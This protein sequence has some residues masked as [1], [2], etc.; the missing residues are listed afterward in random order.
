MS[1]DSQFKNLLSPGRI[2]GMPLR[3]RIVMAPMGTNLGNAEGFTTEQMKRYYEERAKGGAGLITV[4]IAAV[5]YP[6]G[7]GMVNQLGISDDKFMPGLSELAEALQ[8]HGAKAAIQLHH[9]GKI[10]TN[11]MAAGLEPISPS[12]IPIPLDAVLK[13]LTMEE[14]MKIASRFTTIPEGGPK[15]RELSPDEI[16]GIVERYAEAADRAKR[17]SFDGVEIHS[18]H[19]YLIGQFL[20][21]ASNLR[22]DAYGGDLRN[23][24]RLLVEVIRAIRGSVGPHYPVWCRLDSREYRTENGITVEEAMEIAQMAAEAGID[25]LH[26]SAYGGASGIG[27]SE[28]PFVTEPGALLPFAGRI[29]RAVNIPVIA[30][31]R[32]SP[33]LGERALRSDQAD[34]ISIGRQLLADPELPNKLA[35]DRA[36]DIRP[37][38]CC[39]TC[40]SQIYINESVRCVV[41]PAVGKE[42][43]FDVRPAERPKRVLVVGGGPGG[44]QAAITSAQRGHQVTLC[45]KERRLGG[46][47]AFAAIP[48]EENQDLIDY[49][50][51]QIDRLSIDVKLEQD[52]SQGFINSVNPDAVIVAVGAKRTPPP[53][54]GVRKSR[55]LDG[56]DLRQIM[57]GQPEGE[58]AQKLSRLD[59][60]LLSLGRPVLD[61]TSWAREF[62]KH[63]LPILG[64]RI[65]IIG[66]DLVGCELAEFLVERGREI[67]ILEQGDFLAPEM[68]IVRRWRVLHNLREDGV[69]IL[70]GVTC[71]EITDE[72]VLITTREGER[73]TIQ[74]DHIIVAT[75][76]EPNTELFDLVEGKVTDIHAIGDCRQLRLIDGSITDGVQVGLTI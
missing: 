16:P 55:V 47:L 9:A 8:R 32:I 63:W 51:G 10:A 2:G 53:I 41:N 24:A 49:M 5:D 3:N 36:K 13:D 66:G 57:K 72:G 65:A 19:G 42:A 7:A 71:D 76:V 26:V 58:T 23:R 44:M 20:S 45:D 11:D 70:T 46:A 1:E 6:R 21:R 30:V 61:R 29:R 14:I 40:G 39:Y 18:G 31:G 56:D 74:A 68:A 15:T 28:A 54:P 75:G 48:R 43:E 35:S 69:T 64:K 27:P 33:E 12:V 67:T 60:L 50:K 52:V 25:A 37:C 59:K 38:I 22:T 17:A 62:T 73:S 34:F 4:E